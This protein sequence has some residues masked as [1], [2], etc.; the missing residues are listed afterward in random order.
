[1][2]TPSEDRLPEMMEAL[3]SDKLCHIPPQD[4]EDD[5]TALMVERL[6]EW[7]VFN[8]CGVTSQSSNFELLETRQGQV[9]D[10]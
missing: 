4:G 6:I 10:G 5:A 1:M 2:R 9:A 7:I 3:S 8:G